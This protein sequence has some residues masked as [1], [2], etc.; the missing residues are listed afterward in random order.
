[1]PEFVPLR[2][3]FQVTAGGTQRIPR[4]ALVALRPTRA[5][6]VPCAAVFWSAAVVS[7]R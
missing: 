3:W 7:V 4:M 5:M 1:M 2:R 6:A